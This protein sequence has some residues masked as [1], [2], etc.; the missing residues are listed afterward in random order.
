M[1]FRFE[2]LEILQMARGYGTKVYAL[3]AK[4]PRPED[5]GLKS[6]MNR[7]VNSI[8]LNIGEGIAKNSNQ[9]FDYHLEISLGSTFEV[10]TGSFIAR[11]AST[12][13]SPGMKVCTGTVGDLREALMR[14]ETRSHKAGFLLP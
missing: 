3:T 6:Q 10:V 7:A 8:S 4:F 12:L 9:A 11:T 1:A 5:Y 2:T 13:L 14:S